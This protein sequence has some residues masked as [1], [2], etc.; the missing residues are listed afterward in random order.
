MIN[1]IILAMIPVC[2]P[3][4]SPNTIEQII[5]V[6]SEGDILAINVNKL[7]KKVKAQTTKEASNLVRKYISEGYSVDIG[8][9]QVN[10]SNFG[11]LGYKNNEIEALF[12]PCNNIRAGATILTDF[13]NKSLKHHATA[14]Q[15]LRGALSAYNT[16]DFVKGIENGYVGKIYDTTTVMPLPLS[17]TPPAQQLLIQ[18][19]QAKTSINFIYEQ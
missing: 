4:V 5:R 7:G 9:M 15:A 19:I 17:T 2:A 12:E 14:E 6:E 13:Y 11:S 18:A 8:L 1:E 3:D 16:G 10:S